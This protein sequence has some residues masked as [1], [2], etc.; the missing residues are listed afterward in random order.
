M[1]RANIAHDSFIAGLTDA[2][3][4]GCSASSSPSRLKPTGMNK[5]VADTWTAPH[6]CNHMA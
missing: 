2:S 1:K 3:P 6:V 4:S 5:Q